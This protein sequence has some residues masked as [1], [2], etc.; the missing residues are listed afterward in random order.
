MLSAR[1]VSAHET[2]LSRGEYAAVGPAVTATLVFANRDAASVVTD[3]FARRVLVRG[4]DAPC[5]TRLE[6]TLP[7]EGDGV[8]VV[9]RA[10]CP[11]APRAVVVEAAFLEALPFGHKHL[12][13]AGGVEATL[14][15]SKRALSFAPTAPPPPARA[16]L[17]ALGVEHILTGYDHLVFLLGL[18][19]AARRAR[20]LLIVVTA[21]TVGH[22]ISL[23]L[24]A[25]S[26]FAPRPSIVEPLI[27]LSIVYVGVENLFTPRHRFRVAAAFGLLHG[28]GFA[29]A[30]QALA[31][32]RGELPAA[33]ALF[34]LG[35]ELGQLL[36][37][38]VVAPLVWWAQRS[39]RL[40]T[41]G[42]RL[43]NYAI[44][45]AGAAWFLA[46]LRG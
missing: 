32:P 37:L 2:G 33:L 43:L 40:R 45:A 14:T 29:G 21:F 42:T 19:L 18:V 11:S 9:V 41:R 10:T 5:P 3:T 36:A 15:V 22:S 46:R 4:D 23:A 25:L 39:E 27:A 20:E 6:S 26:V 8:Q 12:A 17:L 31:V 13:R 28:F 16:S 38:A 1:V 7:V 30:L 44:I 35:V 24:A 34:N